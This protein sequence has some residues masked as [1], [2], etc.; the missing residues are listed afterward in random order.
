MQKRLIAGNWKMNGTSDSLREISPL[1]EATMEFSS[2]VLIC[3]PFTLIDRAIT[4]VRGSR[5]MIGAQDCHPEAKGPHTGDVSARMLAEIGA[6]H[7]ITGH[8]ERRQN[9]RE[10]NALVKAKATAALDA[11]LVSI[12][13]VGETQCDRDAGKALDI[14][15]GQVRESLPDVPQSGSIVVAYE[16]VWA[17][18]TGRTPSLGD[19]EEMHAHIRRLLIEEIPGSQGGRRA[20]IL[21]GGSVTAKNAAEIF[22]VAN[23]DGGLV[24]GA[25]LRASDFLPIC[26]ILEQA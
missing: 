1:I 3:T 4:H 26:R 8:S 22:S 24:G 2:A 5:L 21:Y 17:I 6:T 18:G 25:S 19:I 13:C 20:P 14:V 9:H 12:V 10:T 11:G 15:S 16:P 7:V 23:V